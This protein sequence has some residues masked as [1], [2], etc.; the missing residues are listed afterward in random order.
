MSECVD[1]CPKDEAPSVAERRKTGSTGGL[2]E[3]ESDCQ[4]ASMQVSFVCPYFAVLSVG[5]VNF[6]RNSKR[7]KMGLTA[8]YTPLFYFEQVIKWEKNCCF[9]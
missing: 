7:L 3:A 4:S 2:I 5:R 8:A 9:L 6:I 1:G